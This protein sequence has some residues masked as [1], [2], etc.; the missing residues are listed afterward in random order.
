M[1]PI[2]PTKETVAETGLPPHIPRPEPLNNTTEQSPPQRVILAH[3]ARGRA[4]EKQGDHDSAIA[5]Y[6]EAISLNPA[7]AD[8]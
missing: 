4:F 3:L 6:T 1:E 7:D 8:G 2:E 5:E